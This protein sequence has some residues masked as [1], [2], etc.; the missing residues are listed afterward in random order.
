[1]LN[2]ISQMVYKGKYEAE[3]YKL[4]KDNIEEMAT[5]TNWKHTG[6]T[7][8]PN[9]QYLQAKLHRCNM[10]EYIVKQTHTGNEEFYV[11]SEY[12]FIQY[13]TQI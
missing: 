5:W 8:K 6:E 9:E 11:L 3:A 13:L 7:H 4:T 1:M 10:G 12:Q 2:P